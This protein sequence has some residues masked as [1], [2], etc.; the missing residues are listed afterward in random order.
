MDAETRGLISEFFNDAYEKWNILEGLD[1]VLD[2][3]REYY[4]EI[5][6]DSRSKELLGLGYELGSLMNR[7]CD[8]ASRKKLEGKI[9]KKLK[10]I[11]G[12][13]LVKEMKAKGGR[14]I[15]SRLTEEEKDYVRN[16][17]ILMIPRLMEKIR[18]ELALKSI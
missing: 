13:T 4:G 2:E 15:E 1:W 5:E 8:F 12:G 6:L 9:D 18:K 17:L 14:R 11:S 7:A 16:M 10:K 3:V